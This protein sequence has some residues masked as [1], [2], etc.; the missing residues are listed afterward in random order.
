MHYG[1]ELI[2]VALVPT[3]MTLN[4]I[5]PKNRSEFLAILGCNTQFITE[6]RRNR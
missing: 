4:D 3:S 1:N 6:L 2:A 5:N